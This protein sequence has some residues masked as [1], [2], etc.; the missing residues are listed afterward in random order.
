M[1]GGIIAAG[2]GER[3]AAAGLGVPKPL[4]PVAGRTLIEWT[5][6]GFRAAG[7]RRVACIINEESETVA[8]HCREHVTDLDLTFVRR[9]TPSSMESLFTLAP[10][11]H[12][13]GSRD[14]FLV[15]TVD[16]I[17][18]PGTVRDF[19]AAAVARPNGDGVLAITSFVDDE[20]PLRVASGSDGRI[21]ALGAE[22][23]SSPM[24]TAGFYVFRPTI[25]AEVA[26]AR[27]A[28][29][30]ALRQFLR[31]LAVRGYGLYGEPVPKCVDVDRP[32][33]L[34]TAEAFVRA[35]YAG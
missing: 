4:V 22:A 30:T 18:A 27:A 3:L 7:I 28:R 13:P 31:H 6:E 12:E 33:D 34:P 16:T 29:F 11:L 2:H 24:V 5:L 17:V 26:A 8:A 23:D 10:L 1:R 14:P 20:K 15:M 32:E 21:T 25:F 35:G 9:T 19:V